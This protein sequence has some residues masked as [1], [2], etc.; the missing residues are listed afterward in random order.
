MTLATPNPQSHSRTAGVLLERILI[1]ALFAL[2]LFGCV[3]L[4]MLWART[5]PFA[6]QVNYGEGPLLY[7]AQRLS[8]GLV[9]YPNTFN[10]YPYFVTEHP[11]IIVAILA[12]GIRTFGDGYVF[13]R[14]LA[15]VATV[16]CALCIYGIVVRLQGSRTA[17]G[18]ASLLFLA[19]PFVFAWSNMVRVDLPALALTLTGLWALISFPRR[20]LGACLAAALFTL[21]A[22]SRQT[23]LVAGPLA[24]TCW[25]LAT[26]R[27][28][29][30]LFLVV[31]L[32][33]LLLAFLLLNQITNNGFYLNTIGSNLQTFDFSRLAMVAPKLVIWFV[34]LLAL[35]LL[36]FY[37]AVR[38]RLPAAILLSA[39]FTGSL[40]STIAY[41]KEGADINYFLESTAALALITGSAY[42]RWA[43]N[44]QA[45]PRIV[46]AAL[47]FLNTIIFLQASQGYAAFFDAILA[48]KAQIAHLDAIVRE[49]NGPVLADHYLGLLATNRKQLWLRPFH[50]SQLAAVGQWDQSS[51]LGDIA[52]GRFALI[53]LSDAPPVYSESLA[54]SRWSPEMWDAIHH[55]YRTTRV[56]AGTSIM[57]PVPK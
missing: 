27:R 36:E 33:A 35:A 5:I 23:Y 7:S 47:L 30:L 13:G 18:I 3:R 11:P 8:Q 41:G 38:F 10:T 28:R 15:A 17:G 14:A 25:L 2:L 6:Y 29:V 54:R 4:V 42:A 55:A 45:R 1:S 34:V 51:V 16:I 12:A 43:R 37:R 21:A 46:L 50:F 53:L 32:S 39:Y 48:E 22:F 40:A 26:D 24:A 31:Y 44:G 20:A 52:T 19:S 57:E 56:V 9:I 49:E